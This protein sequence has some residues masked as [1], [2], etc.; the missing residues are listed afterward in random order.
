MYIEFIITIRPPNRRITRLLTSFE[1]Y[2]ILQMISKK[3]S[4]KMFYISGVIRLDRPV[5]SAESYNDGTS[6]GA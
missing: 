3:E 5:C 6:G 1:I 2:A 4:D